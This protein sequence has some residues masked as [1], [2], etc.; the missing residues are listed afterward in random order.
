MN[1]KNVLKPPTMPMNS[2]SRENFDK[3]VI[4]L[5]LVIKIDDYSRNIPGKIPT[6]SDESK[7]IPTS[8]RKTPTLKY[9]AKKA[10]IDQDQ[11]AKTVDV[12]RLKTG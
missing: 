9:A 10:N 2:P 8:T 5:S 7:P 1:G 4:C 11:R 6:P 12:V 3:Q